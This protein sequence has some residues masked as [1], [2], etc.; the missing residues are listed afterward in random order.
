[1]IQNLPSGTKFKITS[2]SGPPPVDNDYSIIYTIQS[3]DDPDDPGLRNANWKIMKYSTSS[4]KGKIP[5]QTTVNYTVMPAG[6]P[7]Q[8]GTSNFSPE[9]YSYEGPEPS[10]EGPHVIYPSPFSSPSFA[11]SPYSYGTNLLN[12]AVEGPHVMYPSP[13]SNSPSS[14]YSIGPSPL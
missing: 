4:G 3:Y 1:M 6:S 10:A 5:E 9:P 14:F 12:N 2:S 11:P 8:F 7:S 13:I